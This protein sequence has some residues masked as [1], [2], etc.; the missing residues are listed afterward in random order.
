MM[1]R[2]GILRIQRQPR[3]LTRPPRPQDTCKLGF[4]LLLSLG[5]SFSFCLVLLALAFL[6]YHNTS[7]L[8][9]ILSSISNHPSVDHLR[10]VSYDQLDEVL[11]LQLKKCSSRERTP[12]LKSL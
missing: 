9:L 5:L 7:L 12:D 1:C 8:L 6:F 2:Q 4:R 11:A 3:G 10:T